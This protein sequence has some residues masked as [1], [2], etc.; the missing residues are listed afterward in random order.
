MELDICSGCSGMWLDSHELDALEDKA[1]KQDD[2]KGSLMT[3]VKDTSYPC[4][5]CNVNLQSFRYRFNDLTLEQ[6]SN[7]HGY[8]LDEG[9][10]KKVLEL[11]KQRKKDIKRSAKA[12][13]SFYSFLSYLMG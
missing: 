3:N 4:P 12:E 13:N 7:N 1:F 6:C 9:E 11:M 2:E 5:K 10:D 8:W